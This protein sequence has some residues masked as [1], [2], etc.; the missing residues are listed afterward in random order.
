MG[1]APA[2]DA[3]LC[4]TYL[5]LGRADE[6]LK[7]AERLRAAVP[8]D[9]GALALMA[10]CWRLVGDPRY[11]ALYDYDA[12]V[13]AYTIETPRGW[14]TLSAYLEDLATALGALHATRAH[15]VGQSLRWGSQTN[16]NLLEVDHPALNAFPQA[17]EGPIRTYMAALGEGPDPL[18]ARN[19]GGYRISGIWSVRLRPGGFHLDHVHPDGW[20]SSACYIVLPRTLRHAG[21]EGWIKFGEPG[22]PTSPPLGPE[23]FER[24]EPGRLVLF[25]SYMWHG[26]IPFGGDAPRLTV[27]FDVVPGCEG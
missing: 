18:R 9:Q 19:R 5:A 21:R 1:G 27:A 10:I 4:E 3:T 25:P 15:P 12:F 23:H 24:P 7:A 20:L 16:R 14:P 13:R 26:V 17:V 11:L 2:A 8:D 6:A 22:P